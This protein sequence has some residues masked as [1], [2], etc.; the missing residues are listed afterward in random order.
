MPVRYSSSQVLRWPSKLEVEESMLRWAMDERK[1]HPELLR[2]GYFESYARGDA[3][4]GSDLD[5]V[6]VIR[7]SEA[8]FERRAIDWDL[9]PLPVP[10]EILIYT[11]AEWDDLMESGNRFASM[12][13][14]DTIWL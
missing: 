13:E 3:G 8:P 2:I 7:E 12:L 4:V 14:R 10:A 11:Q 5:I 9:S 6:A 1:R